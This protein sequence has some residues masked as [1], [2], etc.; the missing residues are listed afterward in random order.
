MENVNR[1]K[2]SSLKIKETS[3]NK[4]NQGSNH[5]FS[6]NHNHSHSQNLN[7]KSLESKKTAVGQIG[8]SHRTVSSNA[9]L[10]AKKLGHTYSNFKM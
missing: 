4:E 7:R 5:N 2:E 9:N 3:V 8:K 6:H 10:L 1:L